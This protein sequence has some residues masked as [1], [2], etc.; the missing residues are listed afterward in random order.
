MDTCRFTAALFKIVRA[1][2]K[3]KCPST[4]EWIKKM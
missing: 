2:K 1:S 3:L 4:E